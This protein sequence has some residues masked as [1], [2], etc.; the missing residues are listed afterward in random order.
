VSAFPEALAVRDRLATV[1]RR[2]PAKM[3]ALRA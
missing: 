3:A 1:Q 2:R